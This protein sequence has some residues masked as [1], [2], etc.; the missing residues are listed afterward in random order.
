MD[1]N[2]ALRTLEQIVVSNNWDLPE[3]GR[4]SDLSAKYFGPNHE[5]QEDMK[6]YARELQL[7]EDAD[8]KLI[9]YLLEAN[10]HYYRSLESAVNSG[11]KHPDFIEYVSH[12]IYSDTQYFPKPIFTHF[13]TMFIKPT[14]VKIENGYS[15]FRYRHTWR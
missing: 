11:R 14:Q 9:G 2:V 12:W 1:I 4:N 10:S 13:S 5:V 3:A 6:R 7:D 8:N 15:Y